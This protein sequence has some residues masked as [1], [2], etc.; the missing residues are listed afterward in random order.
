VRFNSRGASLA[1]TLLL[2]ATRLPG[3][4]VPCVV[5]GPGWL[6]LRDAALYRPYHDAL[7]ESGFAVFVFDYRGFGDSEGGSSVIDP[8]EQVEDWRNAVTYVASRR[9]LD[10]SAIGV[11]GSGGT[12]GGN[13]IVVAAMDERVKATVSQ[14][15]IGDGRDWLRRMRSEDA[16]AAFVDR[17]DRDRTRRAKTGVSEL[18]AARGELTVATAERKTAA[19]KKDVDG[20]VPELVELSSADAL[21]AYRPIDF[22]D[23]IAPRALMVICV[24]NDSTTPDDH[25]QALFDRAGEPKLLVVQC[26]TTH[27]A[28]YAQYRDRIC[29]LIVDWFDA[30]LRGAEERMPQAGVVNLV[31][32]AT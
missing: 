19:V 26:D 14:V 32:A 18:V 5:Q 16:W 21:F 30:Y 11:F 2:P 4:R 31:Q 15:P 8:M 22:V 28:A 24:E 1:G 29:G 12:G 17:V 3:E 23:R 20:R 9:E 6:G 10:S 13:A 7:L 25:A 27:Y